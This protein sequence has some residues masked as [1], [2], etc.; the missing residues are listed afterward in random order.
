[1]KFNTQFPQKE[2]ERSRIVT[3]CVRFVTCEIGDSHGGDGNFRHVECSF[4]RADNGH[5]TSF[6]KVV[7][8]VQ[9]QRD[10]C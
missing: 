9:K 2:M 6:F 3:L 1:M 4:W 10:V 7:F 5:N 8:R